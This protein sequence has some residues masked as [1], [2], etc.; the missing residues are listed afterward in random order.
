[1][2]GKSVP[3]TNF[4]ASGFAESFGGAPVGLYFWHLNGSS[5]TY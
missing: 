3:S 2:V 5:Q 4:A 1:M